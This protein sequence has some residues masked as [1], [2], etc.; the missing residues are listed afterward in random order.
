MLH[1]AAYGSKAGSTTLQ[2]AMLSSAAIM[3]TF[4]VSFS[5]YDDSTS[6]LNGTCLD[7]IRKL[8]S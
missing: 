6:A 2:H 5:A 4:S 3:P 7:D 8:D 1:M